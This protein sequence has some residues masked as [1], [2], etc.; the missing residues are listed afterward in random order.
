MKKLFTLAILSLILV[1]CSE[2][3]K[4]DCECDR[5]VST[6]YAQFNIPGYG[7]QIAGY[8]TTINDCSGL[9]QNWS[10]Q[11]YGTPRVGECR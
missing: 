8:F 4:L 5:V 2:E 7:S 9:Q 10:A 1:S 11:M 3:E 6:D